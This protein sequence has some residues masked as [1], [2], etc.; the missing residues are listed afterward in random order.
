MLLEYVMNIIN[1]VTMHDKLWQEWIVWCVQVQT[2]YVS[3]H[4]VVAFQ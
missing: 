1:R 4:T 3:C 2:K